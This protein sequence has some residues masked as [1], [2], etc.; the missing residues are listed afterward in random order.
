[1]PFPIFPFIPVNGSHF[2]WAVTEPVS[3]DVPAANINP[4]VRHVTARLSYIIYSIFIVDVIRGMD[5]RDFGT[6]ST[7]A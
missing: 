3:P 6:V 4:Y 5:M 1:M 2:Y 7:E